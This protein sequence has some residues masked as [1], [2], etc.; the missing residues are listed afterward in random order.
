MHWRAAAIILVSAE[1]TIALGVIFFVGGRHDFGI[2]GGSNSDD[3]GRVMLLGDA[4]RHGFLVEGCAVF[5][6][7]K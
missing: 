5:D 6:E 2:G 4:I 3:G 1:A 7:S